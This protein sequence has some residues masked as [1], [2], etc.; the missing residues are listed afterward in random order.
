MKMSHKIL[1][2]AVAVLMLGGLSGIAEE[3]AVKDQKSGKLPR[4][5]V[6]KNGNGKC[7]KSVN[8][9]G[10][11]KKN[12][13]KPLTDK[14]GKILPADGVKKDGAKTSFITCPGQGLCLACGL[15]MAGKA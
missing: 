3:G 10:K 1:G 13:V 4:C 15:C 6:D 12:H 5:F 2:L 11:C 14:D 8:D 9:G 7:D